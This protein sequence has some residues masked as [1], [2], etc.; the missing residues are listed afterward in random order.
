MSEKHDGHDPSMYR[1]LIRESKARQRRADELLDDARQLRDPYYVSLALFDLSSDPRLDLKDAV[2][3]ADGAL[4]T[5]GDVE[6]LW[7]RAELLV[8][9]CKKIG[10]WRDKGAVQA[11]EK[12]L[13]RALECIESMPEGQGVSDAVTGCAPYLG[14]ERLRPLLA[15]SVLNKGFESE[16]VKAVIRQW[17]KGCKKAG[18]SPDDIL[19]ILMDVDDKAV[20]SRLLGYFYLQCKRSGRPLDSRNPLRAAVETA[21]S[22]GDEERLGTLRYLAGNAS[23]AEDLEIVAHALDLLDDPALRIGLMTALGGSADKAGFVEL[24]LNWFREGFRM[25]SQVLDVHRRASIRMNLA[26]G[27]IRCGED[28]EAQRIYQVALDDCGDNVKL[29]EMICRAMK[30]HGFKSSGHS[31]SGNQDSGRTRKVEVVSQMKSSNNML[32]L[33]DTYEGALKPV[34]LRAVARAAPLCAAFGLDLALMGFPTDD[35]EDL[36]SRVITETNIGRGGRYLREL[37]KQGRVVLVACT[38][39]RPPEDWSG[40]GLPVATTSHPREEKKVGM[41]EAVLLAKPEHPL[42]RACLIMGLGRRG[43]PQSLLDVVPYHLELTGSNVPLETCTVMGVI[44]Q[45]LCQKE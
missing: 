21:L 24:S 4:R 28:D 11:R 30:D 44:A 16:D 35:L 17:A 15:R 33:Y 2:S 42:K 22:L 40:L 43:L 8:T 38:Q 5:A 45:Q 26:K 6:R 12:L 3:A 34:H 29:E 39:K 19:D 37:V 25:S 10:S 20:L 36:I 31:V 32:A 1:R 41:A 7:R 13:D 18:P 14:C 27:F 23:T 9:I